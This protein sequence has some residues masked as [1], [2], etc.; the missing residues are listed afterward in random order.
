MIFKIV[1]CCNLLSQTLKWHVLLRLY[2]T[3]LWLASKGNVPSSSPRRRWRNLK[4][5]VQ[6][7]YSLFP[8]FSLCKR[9]Q[10]NSFHVQRPQYD[11]KIAVI[12]TWENVMSCYF[13]KCEADL[14][15]VWEIH[16][17]SLLRPKSQV[18]LNMSSLSR[19]CT[20][21]TQHIRYIY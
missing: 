16:L 18:C 10:R 5:K 21:Y 9:P 11:K 19:I 14:R 12:T 15:C 20:Q 1:L 2:I 8:P 7:I 17:W 3:S 13:T 6:C 4:N